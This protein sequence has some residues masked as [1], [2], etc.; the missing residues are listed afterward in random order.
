RIKALAKRTHSKQEHE[1]KEKAS[2]EPQVSKAFH[3]KAI[4]AGI[5]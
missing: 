2:K 3:L 5:P 1:E 4:N